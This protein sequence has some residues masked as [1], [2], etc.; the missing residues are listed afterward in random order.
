M[1]MEMDENSLE[2]AIRS[3]IE[4]YDVNASDL[5]NIFFRKPL[6]LT[7][8]VD[9]IE[10][11]LREFDYSE[12]ERRVKGTEYMQKIIL[13]ENSRNIYLATQSYEAMKKYFLNTLC[14]QNM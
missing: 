6:F 4:K 3:T 10:T 13:S 9:H 2:T 7:N 8:Y 1:D 12:D 5:R 11:Y 14:I